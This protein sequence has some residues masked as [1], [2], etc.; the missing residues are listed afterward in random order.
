MER[1]SLKM[2]MLNSPIYP[3]V[4]KIYEWIGLKKKIRGVR[5]VLEINSGVLFRKSLILV[6]GDNN[7]IRIGHRC[8]FRN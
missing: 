5:N 6:K 2:R 1:K 8:R 4:T 7:K 3:I